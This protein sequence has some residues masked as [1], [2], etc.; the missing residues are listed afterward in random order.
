MVSAPGLA[1]AAVIASRNEQ[2]ALHTPSAVSAVL[3]TVK[4]AASAGPGATIEAANA[5]NSA[6]ATWVTSGR[7]IGSLGIRDLISAI[8]VESAW[9][10]RQQTNVLRHRGRE[11]SRRR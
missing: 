6:S 11:R 9:P 5:S 3:V 8:L 2:S 10:A 4:P 7:R 1:L